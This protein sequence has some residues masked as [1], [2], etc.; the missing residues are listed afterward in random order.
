[1]ATDYKQIEDLLNRFFEGETTNEEEQQ[2][3]RFFSRKD[4]P[5]HLARYKP[6]FSYF[7]N[8]LEGE[9]GQV[10]ESADITGKDGQKPPRQ[11]RWITLAIS[12]AA[13][14]LILLVLSPLLLRNTDAFNPYEGSYIIRNGVRITDMGII[15]PELEAT[16]QKAMQ[17]E[18][19]TS[20]MLIELAKPEASFNQVEQQI[21]QQHENIVNRF[22]DGMKEEI[23]KIIETK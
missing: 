18:E 7:E 22:P 14:L 11:R 12:A 5:E 21:K 19:E 8:D 23:R 6:V 9:L 17:E 1:M 2:L 10:P 13:T 3:Y 20:R 16:L 15:K 4:I